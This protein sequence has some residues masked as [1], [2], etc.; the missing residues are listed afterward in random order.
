M[1]TEQITELLGKEAESLLSHVCVKIPKHVIHETGSNHVQQIFS[2]SDR[3]KVVQKNLQRLYGSGRLAHTG[4]LSIFPVDQAMEH[5][6]AYSFASNPIYFDPENIIRMAI[7]GGT[8]GVATTLGVL[9]L[10]AKKYADKI[11]FIVKINHSEHLTLPEITDQLLFASVEQAQQLG[12][13]G[14]GATIYFGSPESHR[15][16]IE[17]SRAFARAHELGLFTILWCYPRSPEYI[18]GRKDYSSSVDITSQA[19]QIGVT[20]EADII[21]QKM[22]NALR[23]FQDLEFSKYSPEMYDRLLTDH[24][25]DLVRYQ[26]A[27]SYLG[28][29]GLINS[30]GEANGTEDMFEA[31]RSA[32]INKRGGGSGLIMGRKVFKRPFKDGVALLHAVQDVYLDRSITIA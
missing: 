8:N 10:H 9:G 26:L 25:I 5:T 22:P 23:G 27:H 16:I 17:I 11:P 6:A 14:I 28:K 32:V 2:R 7:E 13:A 4:Y 1:T 20:I 15:Q 31:V 18:K 29:I 3:S 12:A 30:G 24:P 19:I 21:K